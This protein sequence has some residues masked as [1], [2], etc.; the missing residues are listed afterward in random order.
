MFLADKTDSHV[1]RE[2]KSQE[3]TPGR[4]KLS[5]FVICAV[6][7]FISADVSVINLALPS[8]ATDLKASMSE[9]QWVIASYNIALAGLLL[10][11]A[12]IGERF[13]YKSAFLSGVFL[14]MIGSVSAGLGSTLPLL[15]GSRVLMGIGGALLIAPALSLIAMIFP[16][17]QRAKA[18]ATWA[19]AGGIGL[20]LGP[21]LGGVILMFASFQWL[22]LVNVP[23][24]LILL[25]LGLRVL[26][27]GAAGKAFPLDLVGASLSVLGFTLFLAGLIEAPR[28]GWTSPFILG[29]LVGG[30]LVIIGF[31]MWELRHKNP[32]IQI[33]ILRGRAVVAGSLTLFI[34]Y[35]SFTGSLFLVTQQLQVVVGVSTMVVGLCI[36]PAALVFWALST[37]ASKVA[38]RFGAARTLLTGVGLA[39]AAFALA[40]ATTPMKS[41]WMAILYLCVAGF[42]WALIIPVATTMVINYLPPK[43]V[44]SG[45]GMSM[46]SRFLGASFGIAI[47]GSVIASITGPMQAHTDLALL[48]E[49]IR[50]AYFA[51]AVVALVGFLI[52]LPLLRGWSP[53]EYDHAE[54]TT[55]SGKKLR[56][57]RAV[58]PEN[59]RTT[60]AKGQIGEGTRY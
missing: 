50:W 51:G 11:G 10:L 53:P 36:A 37:R 42:G 54:P 3:M 44:S 8:I 14:F 18:I 34:C 24:M 22:F 26:P 23:F 20:A 13:G 55:P 16:L 43:W 21:V 47:L 27:P 45:S 7:F 25:I 15:I 5:L 28:A 12:G 31:V 30:M 9:L 57:R 32:M 35:I 46:L 29:L 40:A 49:G 52:A 39:C 17:E 58:G 19:A 56:V 48:N 60:S 6:P 2:L 59:R 38:E 33:R 4:V 41:M 1:V